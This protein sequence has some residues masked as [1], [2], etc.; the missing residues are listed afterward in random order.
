MLKFNLAGSF[1]RMQ[2][3]IEGN[4][5]FKVL[6][7]FLIGLY[8]GRKGIYA[9]L[10]DNK[11][12]L[13]KV[14]AY[15]FVIGLPVSVL[16]AWSAMNAHPFGLAVH[17][18]IYAVSVV[19]L[20][21]SYISAICLWYSKNK[22]RKFFEIFAAPGLKVLTR[23]LMQSVYGVFI[24]YGIGCRFGAK[25]GIV[26]VELIAAIEFCIHIIYS[27]FWLKYSNFGLLEWSWR[28][29]TYGKWLKLANQKTA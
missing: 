10:Q 27:H 20:S 4:R 28:M 16:Y 25:S 3:F 2:E 23:Y 11:G 1:I 14:M 7:L 24:F 6:G 29:L 9:N 22:E 15:G 13:K 26:Y 5:A 12:F 8:I 19:P 21:F 18:A 17:S